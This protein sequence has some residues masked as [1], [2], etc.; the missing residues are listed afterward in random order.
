MQL[1]MEANVHTLNLETNCGSLNQGEDGQ[2]FD[3][4]I[5]WQRSRK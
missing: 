3:V 1:Y 5:N 2:D 4:D